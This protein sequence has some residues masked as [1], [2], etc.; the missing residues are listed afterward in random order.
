MME[1]LA[2]G[3]L[4]EFANPNIHQMLDIGKYMYVI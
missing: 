3:D 2:R 1:T 4:P